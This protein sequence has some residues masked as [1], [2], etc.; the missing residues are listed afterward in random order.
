MV[1]DFSATRW[2]WCSKGYTL[3]ISPLFIVAKVVQIHISVLG[4]MK[5]CCVPGCSGFG[6]HKFPNSSERRMQWRVA[7]RRIDPRTKGLWMP[8][9]S[10]I[11]CHKHF[12]ESDYKTTLMGNN[13]FTFLIVL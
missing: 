8:S 2:R 9:D 3:I 10:A 1:H 12:K 5:Y 4:I 6:G 7:I 11:V 13:L